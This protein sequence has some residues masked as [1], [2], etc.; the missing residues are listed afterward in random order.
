MAI[1]VRTGARTVTVTWPLTPPDDAVITAVPGATPLTSPLLFTEATDVAFDDQATVAAMPLPFWSLGEAVSCKVAPA[2]TLVPPLTVMVVS[3]SGAVTVTVVLVLT[4][5]EVA[6]M[7]AVPGATPVTTPLP[8]TVAMFVS[9]DD[10]LTDAEMTLPF[11]SL[12]LA[13]SV[14]VAPA[15][16]VAPP[17]TEMDV[18][19][20]VGVDVGVELSPPPEQPTSAAAIAAMMRDR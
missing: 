12:G 10:Q 7:T 20:G 3:T 16:T 1:V 14:R 8:L 9:P 6:L 11:W 5:P 15:A 17:E 2:T 4:L 19:T 13:T 18:S